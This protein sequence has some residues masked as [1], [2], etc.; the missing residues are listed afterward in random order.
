MHDPTVIKHGITMIRW[1][2]SSA[3]LASLIL[4]FTT[5]FQSMGKAL[6]ALSFLSA[7]R[8]DLLPCINRFPHSF[9]YTRILAK[10]ALTS[11]LRSWQLGCLT[12]TAHGSN[13]H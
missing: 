5:M 13:N 4:V 10:P 7:A 9:G 12:I 11:L 6:P 3:T 8:G 1:L 2:V